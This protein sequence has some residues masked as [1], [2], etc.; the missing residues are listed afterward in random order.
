MCTAQT[1]NSSRASRSRPC[2]RSSTLQ[3]LITTMP[4]SLCGPWGGN[5]SDYAAARV[6]RVAP[7]APEGQSGRVVTGIA[8]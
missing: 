7:K 1:T 3:L 8:L 4:R 5:G 2:G 6:Q